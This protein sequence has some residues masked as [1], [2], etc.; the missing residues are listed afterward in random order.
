MTEWLLESIQ[1]EKKNTGHKVKVR[2]RLLMR[3]QLTRQADHIVESKQQRATPLS[4]V[5]NMQRQA[6]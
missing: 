2:K 5:L 3:R 4:H 6:S 1:K